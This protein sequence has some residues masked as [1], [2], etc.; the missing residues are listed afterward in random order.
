MI[1]FDLDDTLMYEIDFLK[2]AYREI[3]QKIEPD[4]HQSLF[5]EMFSLYQDGKDVFQILAV[6]FPNFTKDQLLNMY[7][8]H[9][10][11]IALNPGA[12]EVFS[13]CKEKG[14]M[15]GL[16]TDGRSL[17]QRNKLK[18]LQIENIFDRII[19]SEEFGSTKPDERNFKA[20]IKEDV[21][22]YYY[23]ADNPKKDF[24]IPNKLGWMSICLLDCGHN[25]HG[26]NFNVEAEY[27]PKK[28]IQ[29]LYELLEKNI[30]Y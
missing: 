15:M 9:M 6:R 20:F 7:R 26:Q 13:F 22:D 4:N 19:I 18:A 3:V 27:L 28:N 30:I 12:K 21:S 17:T 10:P 25:I 24:I 16:L 2:S 29:T 23:I 11:Q 5:E 8:M 14:Y 1:I